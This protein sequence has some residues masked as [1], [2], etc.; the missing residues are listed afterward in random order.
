M[1]LPISVEDITKLYL[2]GSTTVPSDLADLNLAH[3]ASVSPLQ[4][5]R[6]SYMTTGPGRF[7]GPAQIEIV[8]KFFAGDLDSL[9]PS[10]V[11]TSFHLSAILDIPE[12]GY[13][14]QESI[15]QLFYNDGQNDVTDRAYIFNN[16]TY[17][18]VGDPV[19][20]VNADGSHEIHDLST[21]P[22]DENFDFHGGSAASNLANAYL[23]PRID[24]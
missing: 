13:A 22:R 12:N 21:A 7:G 15:Q 17:V 16:Q 2:F 11:T 1:T 24:P 18:L 3:H 19:F 10:G 6:Y 8:Q 14:T 9:F 5:D 20:V 4:F 23:Q